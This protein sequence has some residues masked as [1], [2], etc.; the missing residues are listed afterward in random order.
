M[1]LK[2]AYAAGA[3]DFVA[4]SYN[5]KSKGRPNHILRAQEILLQYKRPETPVG[6]VRNARE[7]ETATISR[8]DQFTDCEIDMFST[9][10]IGNQA[11]YTHN[12]RMIT[13][14]GYTCDSGYRTSDGNDLAKESRKEG[15]QY[16]SP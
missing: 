4:G 16:L 6:I 2:N 15:F 11:T 3:G 1:S 14:R 13:P 10:I 8:L 9:V 5:P 7:G 12:N